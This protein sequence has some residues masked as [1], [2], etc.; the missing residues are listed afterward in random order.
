MKH[1]TKHIGW[2]VGLYCLAAFTACEVD[3]TQYP[4]TPQIEFIEAFT[5]IGTDDLGNQAKK[6][7]I[8]F[9]LIDGDGDM[10]L[11]QADTVPPFIDEFA[12]NFFP[13][14][15]IPQNGEFVIDTTQLTINYK[16]PYV[17][18][19]GQDETLKAYILVDFGYT[20]TSAV[21]FPYDSLRYSFY[22][23]DRRLHQSNTV[24]TDTIRF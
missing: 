11:T 16:I 4:T 8:K 20:N 12:G 24:W 9:Y 3:N 13:T 6:V 7:T 2:I 14:L 18:E 21:P 10:G 15:Y 22:V 19:L 23:V 17:G 1:L 5:E